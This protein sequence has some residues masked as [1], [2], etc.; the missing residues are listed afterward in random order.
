MIMMFFLLVG[1]TTSLYYVA[2]LFLSS[3][4]WTSII[5]NHRKYRSCPDSNPV[6]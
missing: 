1:H 2:C 6:V 4:V 5:E 3:Q